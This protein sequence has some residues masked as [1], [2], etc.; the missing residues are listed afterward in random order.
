MTLIAI[1]N[2]S[3]PSAESG[4]V[5]T[6]AGNIPV[7]SII[8]EYG[9][10]IEDGAQIVVVGDGPVPHVWQ[11]IAERF[12]DDIWIRVNNDI[13]T[14]IDTEV[15]GPEVATGHV[16]LRELETFTVYGVNDNDE[17]F[18]AVVS[19][20]EHTVADVA[21]KAGAVDEDYEH[22]VK[23]AAIVKGDQSDLEF[24]TI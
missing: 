3:D 17:A 5:D 18:T 11:Y 23:I 2:P 10:K 15:V 4:F 13:Q 20:T 6:K 1:T 21:A 16:G 22:L 19:A 24:V 8:P 9:D 14:N 7:E 12:I